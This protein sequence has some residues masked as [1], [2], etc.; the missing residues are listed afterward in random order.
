MCEMDNCKVIESAY[1]S[2]QKRFLNVPTI[3]NNV[4]VYGDTENTNST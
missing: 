1:L 3:N 4:F 2:A